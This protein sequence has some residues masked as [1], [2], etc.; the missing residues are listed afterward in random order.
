MQF[1]RSVAHIRTSEPP[2][3][4]CE[5]MANATTGSPNTLTHTDAHVSSLAAVA[6][7]QQTRT[8]GGFTHTHT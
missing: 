3:I 4:H 2:P 1:T 5:R 6:T 8:N 7:T